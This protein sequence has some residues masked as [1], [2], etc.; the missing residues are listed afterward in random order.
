M[1]C[2]CV[3]GSQREG[4]MRAR[5]DEVKNLAQQQSKINDEFQRQLDA[6]L[7]RNAQLEEDLKREV[8]RSHPCRAVCVRVVSCAHTRECRVVGR[9]S[10][11]W[12]CVVS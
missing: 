8:P 3:G 2:V 9:V 1:S 7:A 5:I 11:R 6:Q 4:E 10:C 12:S